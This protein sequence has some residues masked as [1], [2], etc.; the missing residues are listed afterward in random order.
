M[1]KSTIDNFNSITNNPLLFTT[2]TESRYDGSFWKC[3]LST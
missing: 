3:Y 2:T 1:T